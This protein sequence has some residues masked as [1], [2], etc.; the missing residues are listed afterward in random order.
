MK[1]AYK[2]AHREA[3]HDAEHHRSPCLDEDRASLREVSGV[4]GGSRVIGD[5]DGR[6]GALRRVRAVDVRGYICSGGDG[7][8]NFLSGL[9][10][11]PLFTRVRRKVYSPKFAT[12]RASESAPTQQRKLTS[13]VVLAGY[14][15]DS[16][17]ANA[18]YSEASRRRPIRPP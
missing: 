4:A 7:S 11:S 2:A 1:Y 17:P 12:S 6:Y 5:V 8:G 10:S 18:P 14:P 13:F 16:F 3:G 9:W 15:L